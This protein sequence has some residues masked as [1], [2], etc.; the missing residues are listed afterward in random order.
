MLPK[1]WGCLAPLDLDTLCGFMLGLTRPSVE[2]AA[3]VKLPSP[4]ECVQS[5]GRRCARLTALLKCS[6]LK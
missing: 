5:L 6:I 1:Y 4:A 3:T 2:G